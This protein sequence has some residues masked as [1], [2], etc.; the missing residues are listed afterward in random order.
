MHRSVTKMQRPLSDDIHLQIAKPTHSLSELVHPN[1]A[2]E[3][4]KDIS[5]R[6]WLYVTANTEYVDLK[7]Q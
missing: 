5:Y 6:M 1:P 2:V 3:H 7:H 4:R